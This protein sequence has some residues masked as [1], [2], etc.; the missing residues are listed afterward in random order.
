METI[1]ISEFNS[2][3]N[4]YLEELV[5]KKQ[6]LIVTKDGEPYFKVSPFQNNKLKGSI[7]FE[8]DIVSPINDKWE[9][10]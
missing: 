1:T 9:T 3:I 7:A 5:K 8:G 6:N 2:N 10:E 4:Y